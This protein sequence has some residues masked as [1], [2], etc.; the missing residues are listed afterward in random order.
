MTALQ[1]AKR[2]TGAMFTRKKELK[3][4]KQL[5][6]HSKTATVN[7]EE[8]AKALDGGGGEMELK[9]LRHGTPV[10]C[11]LSNIYINDAKISID[12]STYYICQNTEAACSNTAKETFGY[13][14]SWLLKRAGESI[15]RAGSVEAIGKNHNVT[16]LV[17]VGVDR[18]YKGIDRTLSKWW[19]PLQIN[20]KGE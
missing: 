9:D 3:A 12:G 6:D 15:N 1:G 17:I 13:K 10:T 4:Y 5:F 11:R 19:K 8:L 18:A 2:N 16:D 20:E 7:Y 14:Y